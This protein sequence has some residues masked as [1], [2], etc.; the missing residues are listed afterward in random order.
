M[1]RDSCTVRFFDEDNDTVVKTADLLPLQVGSLVEMQYGPVK[2]ATKMM[3]S[4]PCVVTDISNGSTELEGCASVQFLKDG[5]VV[6]D[7]VLSKYVITHKSAKPVTRTKGLK[8]GDDI[9]I[10]GSCLCLA[11]PSEVAGT[12]VEGASSSDELWFGR[13]KAVVVE[14][15]RKSYE[16]QLECASEGEKFVVDERFPMLLRTEVPSLAVEDVFAE[17]EH[18]VP[19]TWKMSNTL[20]AEIIHKCWA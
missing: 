5:V 11:K 12:G 3:N 8:Q 13:I 14:G 9:A 16:I 4:F 15:D 7:A 20:E 18:S 17:R 2:A 6:E 10:H 1:A 19:V